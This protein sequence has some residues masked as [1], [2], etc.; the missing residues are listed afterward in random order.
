VN[1][2]LNTEERHLDR[3]WNYKTGVMILVFG[4][5]VLIA[6]GMVS[7]LVVFHLFIQA[8]GPLP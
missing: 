3:R 6:C 1:D 4:V 7:L 8:G 2:N 5:P